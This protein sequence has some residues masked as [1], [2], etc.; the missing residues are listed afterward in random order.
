MDV[1]PHWLNTLV[2]QILAMIAKAIG[3]S[4]VAPGC[5]AHTSKHE[6]EYR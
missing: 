2:G 4:P 1:L 6:E 5:P 3:G